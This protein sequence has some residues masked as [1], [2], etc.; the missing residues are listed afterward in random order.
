MGPDNVEVW[1]QG[2]CLGSD[3]AAT[4]AAAAAAIIDIVK[5]LNYGPSV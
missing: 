4:A 5:S 2:V 3:A 1:G